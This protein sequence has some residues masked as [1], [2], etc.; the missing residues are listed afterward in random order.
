MEIAKRIEEGEKEV[1]RALLACRVAVADI[2]DIGNKLKTGKLRVRDVVKDAPEETAGRGR[3]GEVAEE[4]AEGEQP[5][6]L[7]Q[8]E[9]NRIEQ[10]CKQIERF[11]KFAKDCEVL[12][13]ELSGKKKLTEV[14]EEGSEAGGEGPPDQDDGGP[15][16]DAAQQEADGPHRPQ[17]ARAHRARGQ[18]RGGAARHRAPLRRAR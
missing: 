5:Q 18:G 12:E 6:Q 4:G 11:R 16:G 14:Q 8:S 1:L 2:L 13:E 7:A 15:G 17:P 3:R 9:L 10:I